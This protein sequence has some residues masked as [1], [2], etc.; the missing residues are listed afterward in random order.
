MWNESQA[1]VLQVDSLALLTPSSKRRHLLILQH[2]QRSS[3]DT[4]GLDAEDEMDVYPSSPRIRLEAATPVTLTPRFAFV[5]LSVKNDTF[6]F[7]N[8]HILRFYSHEASYTSPGSRSRIGFLRRS[9]GPSLSQPHSQSSSEFGLSR[10]GTTDISETSTTDDYVT[11]NTSMGTG[12][13]TGSRAPYL[14]AALS[15]ATAADGSSFESASSVYS[16]ARSEVRY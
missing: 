4:D 13:T 15:T 6:R 9:P 5:F 10:S 12:T 1:T 3:M 14:H 8:A 2:Q 16:L 11:A 7:Y